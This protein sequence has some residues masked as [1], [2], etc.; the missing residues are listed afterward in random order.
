M[1]ETIRTYL[2]AI[3]RKGGPVPLTDF[4]AELGCLPAVPHFGRP[5]GV[6]PRVLD[7]A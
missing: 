4:Q 2:A 1:D 6:L 3:G 5:G 7:G